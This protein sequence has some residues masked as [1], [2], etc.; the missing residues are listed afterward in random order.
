MMRR[1][2]SIA[3]KTPVKRTSM[4]GAHK[5]CAPIAQR[6][7]PTGKLQFVSLAFA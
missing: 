7:P 3:C 4:H 1:A 6:A 5:V 2:V